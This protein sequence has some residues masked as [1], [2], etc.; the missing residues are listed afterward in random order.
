MNLKPINLKNMTRTQRI[1]IPDIQAYKTK[2]QPIVCLT[3]YTT[4]MARLLD[5]HTDLLLVGDSLGM[6]LY[7]MENTLGVSLEMMI[8]H[9]AAVMRAAPKSCVVV[10]MPFGSYEESPGH[11]YRSA[12]RILK[13]TGCDAVKLEGG[14]DM[15]ETIAH[16]T[17]RNIPVMAHI[18]LQPQSVI[19]DGGYKIK[20]KGIAE[21][22]KLMRDARAVE[23]ASAF[24]VVIEGTIENVAS[25]LSQTLGIPTIGIGASAACDGQVLV[26]DDMLGLH[27]GHVP[28]FVKQ[29]KTLARD[30]S[31]AAASYAADVR[32]RAFPAADHVYT[33]PKAVDAPYKGGKA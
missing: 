5:P 24:S 21:A 30:I 26:I 8:A 1:T 18:G 12:A 7:G 32:K 11:A 16:L 29:Y 13:E 17:A 2:G 3:A 28:K 14:V 10:D 15:A 20:G 6:V 25:D 23:A 33:A 27:E 9:G 31:E 22:Q 19:K 4:P